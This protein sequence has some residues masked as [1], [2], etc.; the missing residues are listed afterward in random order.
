MAFVRLTILAFL[1]SLTSMFGCKRNNSVSETK[2]DGQ[3]ALASTFVYQPLFENIPE[4]YLDSFLKQDGERLVRLF[5]S[6][7]KKVPAYL[8]PGNFAAFKLKL[9]ESARSQVL[10]E[11]YAV[12]RGAIWGNRFEVLNPGVKYDGNITTQQFAAALRSIHQSKYIKIADKTADEIYRALKE[13]DG[14]FLTSLASYAEA[15][16]DGFASNS[17]WLFSGANRATPGIFYLRDD[18]V[19]PMSFTKDG[20]ISFEFSDA[21]VAAAYRDFKDVASGVAKVEKGLLER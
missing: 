7:N 5:K 20:R 16:A 18:G 21:Q 3:A 19:P 10:S 9:E 14:S 6:N 15:D 12:V 13:G 4:T 1:F 8:T 11:V 17:K 2:D